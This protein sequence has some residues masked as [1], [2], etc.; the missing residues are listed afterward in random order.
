MPTLK[1]Q[2]KDL[3]AKGLN[4]NVTGNYNFGYEQAVDTVNRIYNA[5][6]QYIPR[7]G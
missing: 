2:V 4:V 1:Y 6:G 7:V 3:F 5:F